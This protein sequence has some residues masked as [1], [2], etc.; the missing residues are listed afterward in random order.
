MAILG[1]HHVGVIVKD[2]DRSIRFYHDTL[3]LEFDS[4]PSPWFEGEELARGVGVPG[5][6]LRQVCLRASDGLIVELLEYANRPADNDTPIQQNY[7]GA[8]HLAFRVDDVRATKAALESAGVDFLS[9]VNTVDEGVLAGWRWVY[10]HD[11][12]GIPLELVE[13]AYVNEA[14]R[15]TGIARYLATRPEPPLT[16][17]SER[18]FDVNLPPDHTEPGLAR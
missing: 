4:E 9:D 15:A 17:R 2:L 12:D 3:G 13:V 8:M 14:A 1:S 11:P 6:R 7:L 18:V 5:A 10:L 16:A